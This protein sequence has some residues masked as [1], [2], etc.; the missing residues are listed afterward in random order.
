MHRC[1]FDFLWIKCQPCFSPNRANS[2]GHATVFV[3]A[4]FDVIQHLTDRV[5]FIWTAFVSIWIPKTKWS[6]K[7]ISCT[8]AIHQSVPIKMNFGKIQY[9]HN[10][11][12]IFKIWLTW[13]LHW[14]YTYNIKY[15]TVLVRVLRIVSRC[16]HNILET[17]STYLANKLGR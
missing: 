16:I 17:S 6:L 9:S 10:F 4:F 13:I 7:H 8:F 5:F 3:L 14:V 2:E 11:I 12:T 1:Y 15:S